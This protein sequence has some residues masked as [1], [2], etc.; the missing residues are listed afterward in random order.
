MSEVGVIYYTV[1]GVQ[2]DSACGMRVLAGGLSEFYLAILPLPLTELGTVNNCGIFKQSKGN[3]LCQDPR[4]SED[5]LSAYRSAESSQ[6][7][8][9]RRVAEGI[10]WMGTSQWVLLGGVCPHSHVL[11]LKWG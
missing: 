3:C 4:V 1:T 2:Q 11:H 5:T 7:A 8:E 9:L 6:R 10:V